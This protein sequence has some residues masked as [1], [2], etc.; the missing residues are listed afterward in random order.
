MRTRILSRTHLGLPITAH[1][2]SP[3]TGTP[4]PRPR[5]LILGG[6][7]GDEIEGVACAR[8][9]L[10]ALLQNFS[11]GMGLSFI[12]EVNPEGVILKTRC[13]SRGVDL[14]RNLPTKDWSPEIKTPRYHPG[15]SPL[16]EA[17]NK[18]LVQ[19]LENKPNLIVSL[20]SWQPML[21]VNGDCLQDAEVLSKL[22]GYRIDRD[23]G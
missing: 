22:T 12:P 18:A 23:I 2:F 14:N 3:P 6:V 16:S 21:N 20:H 19:E 11:F 5:V 15:P 17:E 10:D 1:D 8:A 4:N 9:L 7:H 13:N